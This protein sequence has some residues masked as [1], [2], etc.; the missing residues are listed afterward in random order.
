MQER[1]ALSRG[2]R[3]ENLILDL[4]DYPVEALEQGATDT[5]Q[6]DQ[7][8]A[9]VAGVGGA[10]DQIASFEATHCVGDIPAVQR[11][12]SA[13]V[14][15]AGPSEVTEHREDAVLI[16]ARTRLGQPFVEQ[17]VGADGCL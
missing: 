10:A 14:S 13:K 16:A 12:G 5:G 8:L 1:A 7:R 11:S 4:I 2:E 3:C 15:L 9:G 17:L 6:L